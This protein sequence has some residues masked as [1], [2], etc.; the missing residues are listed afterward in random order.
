M[1]AAR[2]RG[3]RCGRVTVFALGSADSRGKSHRGDRRKRGAAWAVS[4]GW[5]GGTWGRQGGHG[6]GPSRRQAGPWS[7]IAGESGEAA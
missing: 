5:D 3:S 4:V 2:G 7:G 6:L 1:G